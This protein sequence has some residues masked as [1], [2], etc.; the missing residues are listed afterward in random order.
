MDAVNE[1]VLVT[2]R[3]RIFRDTEIERITKE[4]ELSKEERKKQT[5]SVIILKEELQRARQE[6][7]E[8]ASEVASL[9]TKVEDLEAGRDRDV[10]RSSR[11]ARREITDRYA[12][13]PKL[14]EVKWADKEK[15]TGR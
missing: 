14:L 3:S 5:G 15:E 13:A 1:Y 9:R 11:L 7:A 10:R 4:L 6:R 12:D 2:E 8:F